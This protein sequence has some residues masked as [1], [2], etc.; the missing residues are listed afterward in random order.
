MKITY[1][2]DREQ[3]LGPFT[4]NEILAQ[5]L[6]AETL[7]RPS[8]MTT[9]VAVQYLPELKKI[10]KEAKSPKLTFV[11]EWLTWMKP[12]DIKQKTADRLMLI[13]AISFGLVTLWEYPLHTEG[14]KDFFY[15]HNLNALVIWQLLYLNYVL[16]KLLLLFPV[17]AIKDRFFKLISLLLWLALIP[18]ILEGIN[19]ML[20]PYQTTW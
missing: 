3:Q 4:L 16:Y 5:D 20:N 9:W 14:A 6:D 19:L 13:Y 11:K 18:K 2:V 8:D 12:L 15:E 10:E 17:F 1:L 7:V